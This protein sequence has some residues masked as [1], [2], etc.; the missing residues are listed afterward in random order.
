[1]TKNAILGIQILLNP[2]N[3]MKVHFPNEPLPGINQS[4]EKILLSITLT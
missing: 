3:L 2:V 4:P 1:M